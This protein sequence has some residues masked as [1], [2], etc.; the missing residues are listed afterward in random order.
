MKKFIGALSLAIFL[1]S[2]VNGAAAG[3]FLGKDKLWRPRQSLVFYLLDN[4]GGGFKA[5][6]DIRDMNV[7]QEG[8]R[9]AFVFVVAPS[10]E[11]VQQLFI[12]D[13][14][15]VSGN[16]E[17]KDGV[18]DM[19]L[20][21]RYREYH[22]VHSPGGLPPGKRRS[23]ALVHPEKLPAR[24]FTLDVPAAGKGIYR[25]YIGGCWD[26]W[27]S[28]STSRPMQCGVHPGAGAMHAHA[29]QLRESYMYVPRNVKDVSFAVSGEVAPFDRSLKVYDASGKKL[30][31]TPTGGI[32]NFDIWRKAAGVQVVKLELDG[33]GSGTC[34]HVKGAPFILFPDAESA[35]AVRGGFIDEQET[36]MDPDQLLI[37]RWIK[38][39]PDSGL[40]AG[41]PLDKNLEEALKAQNI[42]RDSP[43]FGKMRNHN[44]MQLLTK[45]VKDG[46]PA[47]VKRLVLASLGTRIA[48]WGH[49]FSFDG[50]EA[51]TA[52]PE[53]SAWL[54]RS[55]WW[56]L[57]DGSHAG[58]M[59]AA[60]AHLEHVPAE[61]NAAIKRLFEKWSLA[62][63]V[64]EQ[65][66]CSNQWSY[67]LYH[68]SEALELTESKRIKNVL[69]FQVK[70]FC[71]ENN[72]GRS[73]PDTCP[74][75]FN[76][77]VKYN[78]AADTGMIGGGVPAEV[79]GHDSQYSL[80]S[81]SNM[82]RI[83]AKFRH[84]EILAWLEKYYALKTHMT[85]SRT[86]EA[87]T[88]T[89]TGTCSPA[90]FNSRTRYYTHKSPID[91]A[92]DLITH[93]KL[94]RGQADCKPWPFLEE[95]SFVRDIDNTYFFIKTPSYYAIAY[96]GAGFPPYVLWNVPE[97][98]GNSMSFNGYGSPGYGAYQY[99]VKKPGGISAIWIPGC[100]PV[101]LGSNHNVM[102][103]NAV[104][105]RIPEPVCKKHNPD[106][107]PYVVSESFASPET[108]FDAGKRVL[109]K[110]GVIPYS[111]LRFHRQITMLD[112]RVTVKLI[113]TSE[114]DFQFAELYEAIPLF[115]DNR[116]IKT[117]QGKLELPPVIVTPVNKTSP[118]KKQWGINPDIK[119]HRTKFIS[120][121]ADSG[122]GIKIE[123]NQPV[124]MTFAQPLKYRREA[125]T[126]SSVSIPLPVQ[127]NKDQQFTMEYEILIL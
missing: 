69:D 13:D 95:G 41:K 62:R 67:D 65:G 107:D 33:S 85:L 27:V 116:V 81:T 127:W 5:E 20:D 73:N 121:Q 86:A 38:Q 76:S 112:D 119:P 123:F 61:V 10:G 40:E 120:V 48:R 93:G 122:K 7:Y 17:C 98:S 46:D 84:P 103:T 59:L 83:W 117:A 106:V 75:S 11:V 44:D 125:A 42:D 34:L 87:P 18:F 47:L 70:R 118:D 102:Y 21:L 114:K 45:A 126:M 115:T 66:L 9:P 111:P 53:Q 55:C 51:P 90:D 72:L 82:Y 8:E 79:L 113:L 37:M 3:S 39:I 28:L 29:K 78:A 24:S 99:R 108:N 31:D 1:L 6:L 50:N 22:R 94:W 110:S 64:M 100:G 68:M 35:K 19:Y 60:K 96:G 101:I 105:G 63:M 43:A 26:H 16:M 57:N 54:F 12:P 30:A 88:Q 36:A 25:V 23:P 92:H 58:A 104:W 4:D 2:V 49:N 52:F 80:E 74:N 89:F 71:A 15:I 32:I 14:G 56:P 91:D 109:V 97:F 77:K 124:N